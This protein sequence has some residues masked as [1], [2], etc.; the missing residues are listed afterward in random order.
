MGFIEKNIDSEVSGNIIDLCPVG[1]LTSKPFRYKARAWELKQFDS[2]SSHDGLGSNISVHTYN[3]KIVRVVPKENAKI[4]ENW[5]SDR[6]RFSYEGI[7]KE[8]L[9]YPA[10]KIN[11][12]WHNVSWNEAIK[13]V[14]EKI[15]F[16]KEN[17]SSD[18]ICGLTSGNATN[19]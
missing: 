1:A 2:I 13:L 19:E 17:Y 4:N 7:Y 14:I 8:R 6:D 5:L 11:N 12:E 9:L 16:N 18:S 10:V 15:K 3:D